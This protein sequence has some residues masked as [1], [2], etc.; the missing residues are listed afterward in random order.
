MKKNCLIYFWAII[1]VGIMSAQVPVTYSSSE[2]HHEIKKF[3]TLAN[4]LYVAAHPDDE[5]TRLISWLAN[6]R[7]AHVTYISTTRGGGGQNLIGPELGDEMG[8]IRTQELLGARRIDGGHQFFARTRDFGF[9]KNP[10][11][12]FE[13]WGKEESLSDVVWAMRKLKPDVVINRFDHR[14]AGRTHG[15]HTAAAILGYE[16]FDLSNDPSAFSY[17]LDYVEPWQPA[18]L[19]FNTSW[20]FFGSR[21]RFEEADKSNMLAADIGVF[22][23]L[24]GESNS[25][26][27]GRSRSMHK[28]QGFGAASTRGTQN[29]YIEFLK[30]LPLGDRSDIFEG[31]EVSWDR[32]DP[33]GKL[34]GLGEKLDR[35]YD[36]TA[37]HKSLTTLLEMK[38]AINQIEDDFWR[39]RKLAEV[40]KLILLCTGLFLETTSDRQAAAAGEEVEFTTEVTLR[41]P[42]DIQLTGLRFYPE[43]PDSTM[44]LT[45]TYNRAFKFFETMTIPNDADLTTPY[46]LVEKGTSGL[47]Q[48]DDQ[49][50]RGLPETPPYLYV[51][52]ELKIQGRKMTVRHPVIY[53]YVN[54]ADGEIY[55]RFDILPKATVNFREQTFV[56]GSGESREIEIV[57]RGTKAGI[58]GTL[59]L[60]LPEGWK[61]EE[62]NWHFDIPRKGQSR[63]FTT[64]IVPPEHPSDETLKLRALIGDEVFDR[65]LTVIEYDY[66]PK[67]NVLSQ[68][69]A[70]AVRVDVNRS[71]DRIAYIMGA[72]DDIPAALRQIGYQVDILHPGDLLSAPL[73]SYR[74]IVT[75]IRAYNTI[76][77]LAFAQER[78]FDYVER[79]GVLMVQYNTGFRLKTDQIAPFHLNISRFRVT[80]HNAEVRFLDPEHPV[81]HYPN[82]ITSADFEGWV[83]E[84]G[85]YFADEWSDEFAAVLGSNDPNEPSRDGGL[86]IAPLGE[87]YYIYTG[88]SWFRQLPAGVPGAFRI[89]ANM[90]SLSSYEQQ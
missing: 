5:N 23:P 76:D 74:A 85:L 4:V 57:V 35:E 14:T 26:I 79:G 22:L 61:A 42:V 7:H 80:D 78:L 73:H 60:L 52:Y 65:S 41:S 63:V 75:G 58:E 21:E 47:Q 48:V 49:Q 9:S 82:L 36:H 25:E 34:K 27:A 55:E 3:N 20:W 89:F 31:I 66:I 62:T 29:E 8:V 40:E 33:S 53:K 43:G 19:F 72:G 90:L 28:C 17:H 18:R 84:R 56:F 88:Y 68:A 81:L 54:P 87:G 46:W 38:D 59:E 15:H 50:M 1:S 77:E 13:V 24:L 64:S 6:Y 71:G 83:Q 69:E 2:I 11:E 10:E 70:R 39:A 32:V 86:L 45:L 67:L 16:G 37:P 51:D 30:G 44:D 12:T